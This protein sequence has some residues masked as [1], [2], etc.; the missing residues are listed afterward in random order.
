MLKPHGRPIASTG[1]VWRATTS[2]GGTASVGVARAEVAGS[3]NEGSVREP[4]AEIATEPQED[5]SKDFQWWPMPVESPE[6]LTDVHGCLV[7]LEDCRAG[8]TYLDHV[9][10]LCLS[11]VEEAEQVWD[12]VEAKAAGAARDDA[13]KAATAREI[14]GLITQWVNDRPSAVEAREDAKTW[15]RRLTH[16]ERCLRSLEKRIMAAGSAQNG[17]EQLGR[18]GGGG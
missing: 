5:R 10:A 11:R 18:Y 4:M 16:V 8:L 1:I 17:H 13:P 15:R 2:T 7:E 14:N 9:Y 3:V 6:R 12:N